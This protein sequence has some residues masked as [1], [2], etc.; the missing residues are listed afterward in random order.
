M[1][2]GRFLRG[3][4][5]PNLLW[6]T[7]GRLLV[8]PGVLL[9]LL[10]LMVPVVVSLVSLD[11]ALW[12][13]PDPFMPITFH[14][15]LGAVPP[16][17]LFVLWRYTD[18]GGLVLRDLLGAAVVA[19]WAAWGL[20]LVN[21]FLETE[22]LSDSLLRLLNSVHAITLVV[23]GLCLVLGLGTFARWFSAEREER[24]RL[25]ALMEFTQRI[26]SLDHQ[27]VM[28]GAVTYIAKLLNADGCILYLW[29]EG[30]QLLGPV[31][32]AHNPKSYEPG[33]VQRVMSFKVPRGFGLP[34]MVMQTGSSIRSG[35]MQAEPAAQPIPGCKDLD[36]SCLITPLEIE[37]RR[38]GV[39]TVT[40]LKFHQFTK[41]DMDLVLSFTRQAALVIEHG[42]IVRELS[43]V[44]AADHLT[45][46]YNVNHLHHMLAVEVSRAQRHETTLSLVMI[47]CDLS[48]LETRELVG[49]ERKTCLQKLGQV[50]R[51]SMRLSDH[52]FRS[53]EDEFCLLLPKTS[54]E[55]AYVASERICAHLA[56]EFTRL[57]V[58]ADINVGVAALSEQV[59]DGWGLL[60]AAHNALSQ[61]TRTEKEPGHG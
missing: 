10:A 46:L 61:A 24:Q 2:M 44:T 30:E 48:H 50:F 56:Q 31:A 55:Q 6:R 9:V 35:D 5:S 54:M 58:A 36:R 60:A 53:A 8:L 25:E 59:T 3:R 1:A 17:L 23:G 13:V 27:A 22:R 15:I 43:E 20:T 12:T 38:F 41:E 11:V 45:G 42:R 4:L 19:H 32:G 47:R 18:S 7:E 28:D 29:R 33:F 34:G 39:I 52:G 57:G 49:H 37:G 40:G 51:Q 14:L 21:A 16:A 26:A